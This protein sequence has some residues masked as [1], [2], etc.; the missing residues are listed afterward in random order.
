MGVKRRGVNTYPVKNGDTGVWPRMRNPGEESVGDDELA[1]YSA[2]R[3]RTPGSR[4]LTTK[5]PRHPASFGQIAVQPTLDE[6]FETVVKPLDSAR[7]PMRVANCQ[8]FCRD[9]FRR[10]HSFGWIDRIALPAFPTPN[11]EV[12]SHTGFPSF[13][14]ELFLLVSDALRR[15]VAKWIDVSVISSQPKTSGPLLGSPTSTGAGSTT[16]GAWRA[17]PSAREMSAREIPDPLEECS[18][19][20]SRLSVDKS[21]STFFPLANQQLADFLHKY[22]YLDP[23]YRLRESSS[24]LARIAFPFRQA[25]AQTFGGGGG[26]G[27]SLGD[28]RSNGILDDARTYVPY[29]FSH[30]IKRFALVPVQ[31]DE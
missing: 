21:L 6:F 25:A 19:D 24:L 27:R 8:H 14:A 7:E 9:V 2:S 4:G 31:N 16:L 17:L 11:Q 28:L 23:Y 13:A 26:G 10:M 30:S 3:T 5:T 1:Q 18:V 22:N 29:L 20:S 12:F 15:R